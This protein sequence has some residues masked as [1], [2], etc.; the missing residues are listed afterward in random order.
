MTL[1]AR[2]VINISNF[3]TTKEDKMKKKKRIISLYVFP[4]YA[5]DFKALCEELGESQTKIMERKLIRM[6]NDWRKKKGN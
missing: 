5:E 1:A 3:K 6:V 4:D 2:A